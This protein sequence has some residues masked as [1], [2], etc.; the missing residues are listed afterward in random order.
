MK[1]AF[2]TAALAASIFGGYAVDVSAA[3]QNWQLIQ[4]TYK[5]QEGD[6]LMSIAQEFIKK[7]TYGPR[8][9][10]EFKE[11]IKQLNPELL[12]QDDVVPGET[13]QINYW[14]DKRK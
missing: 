2:I 4:D 10:N 9:I 5:V 8:E 14:V 7:N 3:P 11:G 6:S 1:R 13:L 12:Y